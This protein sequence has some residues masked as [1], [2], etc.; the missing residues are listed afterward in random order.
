MVANAAEKL[1]AEERAAAIKAF[2]ELGLCAQL[3]EAAAGLGWKTPSPI[4]QQA[5]PPLLQGG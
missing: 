2:E 4:Q 3:A 5:V 1:S